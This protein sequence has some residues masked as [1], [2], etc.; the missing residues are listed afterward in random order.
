MEGSARG[1][2]A[3]DL[4]RPRMRFGVNSLVILIGGGGAD[5]IKIIGSG[6]SIG[7]R[8]GGG[9]ADCLVGSIVG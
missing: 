7:R 5:F 1:G 6:S 2:A 9:L 8:G 4:G 3:Q